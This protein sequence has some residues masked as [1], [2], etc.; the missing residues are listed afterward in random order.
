MKST[1]QKNGQWYNNIVK[2]ITKYL[3]V[4]IVSVL[5]ILPSFNVAKADITTQVD[6]SYGGSYT[7][8]LDRVATSLISPVQNYGS[9]YQHYITYETFRFKYV[10]DYTVTY[11]VTTATSQSIYTKNFTTGVYDTDGFVDIETLGDSSSIGNGGSTQFKLVIT[12]ASYVTVF[13]L[14]NYPYNTGTGGYPFYIVHSTSNL[15]VTSYHHDYAV[16]SQSSGGSCDC[17]DYTTLFNS[18]I[19]NQA[20]ILTELGEINT[21]SA[22]A[23]T[24]LTSIN[25]TVS[26]IYNV[27]Q[28]GSSASSDSVDNADVTTDNLKDVSDDIDTLTSTYT[29]NMSDRFEDLTDTMSNVDLSFLALSAQWVASVMYD[30]YN[31]LGNFQLLILVPMILGILLLIINSPRLFRPSET[32]RADVYNDYTTDK[33]KTVHT[34][35]KRTKNGTYVEHNTLWSDDL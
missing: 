24:L 25:S 19:S 7:C 1:V 16:N 20:L 33:Q 10:G 13:L 4:A 17:P 3:I 11:Y 32:V 29:T 12:N 27:I 14:A 30:T 18:M 22:N 8:T 34:V 23:I 21:N 28:N 6:I 5:T 35:T 26:N 9:V 2:R 31:N 15:A